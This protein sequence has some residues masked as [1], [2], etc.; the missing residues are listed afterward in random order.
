MKG[1]LNFQTEEGEGRLAI[2]FARRR[3]QKRKEAAPSARN[4]PQNTYRVHKP[5]RVS[6]LS[7]FTF[8]PH[9]SLPLSLVSPFSLFVPCRGSSLKASKVQES[10]PR[11][12]RSTASKSF[13]AL[14]IVATS[15]GTELLAASTARLRRDVHRG[16]AGLLCR[17]DAI[18]G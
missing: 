14:V 6:S 13:S 2:Y 4:V 1:R 10:K 5:A 11:A 16:E 15:V 18:R 12:P 9:L 7:T 8:Q 3:S 17:I